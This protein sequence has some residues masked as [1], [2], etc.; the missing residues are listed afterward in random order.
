MSDPNQLELA[1]LN[2]SVNARDAMPEGGTLT[3]S[4]RSE[5]V[6]QDADRDLAPGQYICFAISDTGSGM[7]SET[8]AR[9]VEPFFSTKEVGQGTGLGLA[10]V[11]GL[12]AQSGGVF[13]LTSQPGVGTQ[14]SLWIPAT[15]QTADAMVQRLPDVAKA[16]RSAMLLLVDDEELVRGSTPEGLRTLGYDV[17][18][19]ASAA[20]A[21]EHV[22]DG[23]I[24]RC[25]ELD[26][27]RLG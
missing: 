2:L 22:A 8:L 14:A 3:I 6:L 20:K 1:I 19:A 25:D 7:D 11:H 17:V 26:S 15:D 16:R 9:C 13:R 27:S 21:L 4:V 24:P 18:E 10:M 5:R 12:A 23:L